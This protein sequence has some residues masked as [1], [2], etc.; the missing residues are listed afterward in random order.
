MYKPSFQLNL[1]LTTTGWSFIHH[2]SLW[3]I[4]YHRVEFYPP[5][6]VADCHLSQP[7]CC[8]SAAAE[9]PQPQTPLLLPP[10]PHGWGTLDT[11]PELL[12][13]EM[14]EGQFWQS[15][16]WGRQVPW[17]TFSWLPSCVF[18]T[19]FWLQIS[20]YVSK[21]VHPVTIMD[22]CDMQIWGM[23]SDNDKT[24]CLAKSWTNLI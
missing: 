13:Q 24:S 17:S 7:L 5:L 12:G 6:P 3:Q 9:A 22:M 8:K 2:S 10:P 23:K 11:P 15:A 1:I 16:P 14:L 18:R 4:L 20:I 19:C 21:S